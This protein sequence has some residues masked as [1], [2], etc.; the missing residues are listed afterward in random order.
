MKPLSILMVGWDSDSNESHLKIK[1][2][3]Q[4]LFALQLKNLGQSVRK[5]MDF[6]SWTCFE[7]GTMPFLERCCPSHLRE[8]WVFLTTTN[9]LS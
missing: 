7:V 5:T 8:I 9:S 3:C 2:K 4:R 6:F 1:S